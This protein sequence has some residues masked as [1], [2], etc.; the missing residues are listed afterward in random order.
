MILVFRVLLLL[1]FMQEEQIK[2]YVM[3]IKV[4]SDKKKYFKNLKF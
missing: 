4:I 2:Y 1:V 3:D